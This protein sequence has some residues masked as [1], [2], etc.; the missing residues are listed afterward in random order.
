[1]P[2]DS[3]PGSAA[4]LSASSSS[5]SS[6][7]MRRRASRDA[8]EAGDEAEV[9]LDGEVVEQ[10]RLVGDEG[11]RALGGHRVGGEVDARDPHAAGATA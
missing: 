3:S 6:G 1:M 7:G 11:E 9:L 4:R 5:S 8:V 2:R 10:A